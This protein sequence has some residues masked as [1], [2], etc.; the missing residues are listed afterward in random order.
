MTEKSNRKK[1][2]TR[3]LKWMKGF[4]CLQCVHVQKNQNKSEYHPD[5]MV[6]RIYLRYF[7]P[8]FYIEKCE[9]YL[10]RF[11]TLNE[12]E[13]GIQGKGIK[14]VEMNHYTLVL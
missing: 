8:M 2:P 11:F 14:K 10:C 6:V 3:I 7:P 13:I 9:T 1:Q 12:R 5:E 4:T